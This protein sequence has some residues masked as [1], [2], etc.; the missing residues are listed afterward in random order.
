MR[1]QISTRINTGTKPAG[2]LRLFAM[3]VLVMAVLSP[4]A[5]QAQGNYVYVNNQTATNSVSGLFR[6]RHGCAH[7]IERLALCHRRSGRECGLLRPQPHHSQS[8]KQ[9]DIRGQ[10]G[11]PHH[12]LV[13]DQSGQRRTHARCGLAVPHAA[14]AGFLPGHFTG[15][16]AGRQFPVCIE[17]RPDSNFHHQ[18]RR[19]A[20][21]VC[22]PSYR[23]ISYTELLLAQCRAW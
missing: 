11:R 14:H 19:D 13:P 15:G 16:N 20:D 3:L 17:Q 23:D 1:A 7:A 9:P 21:S 12:H 4:L 18:R 22:E 2:L 5:A 6:L 10:Y 8:G